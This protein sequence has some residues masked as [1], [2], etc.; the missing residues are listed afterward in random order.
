[1]SNLIFQPIANQVKSG[2]YLLYDGACGTG[3]MLTVADETLRELSQ[4]DDGPAG[5]DSAGGEE[6]GDVGDQPVGVSEGGLQLGSFALELLHLPAQECLLLKCLQQGCL[7]AAGVGV[8][9]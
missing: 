6:L 2:S 8:E 7:E 1:M 4:A 5:A 9:L 3:G